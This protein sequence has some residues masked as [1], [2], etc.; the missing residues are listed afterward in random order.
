MAFGSALMGES[1]GS[2][3]IW[4]VLTLSGESAG[5]VAVLDSLS[6][7]SVG[8]LGG[9]FAGLVPLSWESVVWV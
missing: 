5:E 1:V 3:A 6:W 2:S 4:A 9:A 7:E 8:S